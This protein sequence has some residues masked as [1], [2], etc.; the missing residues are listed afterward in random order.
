MSRSAPA[1]DASARPALAHGLVVPAHQ[2]AD[3]FAVC[4]LVEDMGLGQAV[5]GVC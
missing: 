5:A 4:G 1:H 3:P 2:G